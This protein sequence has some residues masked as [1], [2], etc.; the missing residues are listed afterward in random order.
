MGSEHA[1]VFEAT[2]V[3]FLLVVPVQMAILGALGAVVVPG[4]S[5]HPELWGR[6]RG[7]PMAAAAFGSWVLTPLEALPPRSCELFDRIHEGSG[8]VGVLGWCHFNKQS[9][10]PQ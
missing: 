4:L 3:C 8:A 6:G 9:A 10:G 7:S 5:F 1:N 2:R